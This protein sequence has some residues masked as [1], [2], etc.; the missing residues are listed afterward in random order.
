MFI[1][2]MLIMMVFV[3]YVKIKYLF[4]KNWKVGLKCFIESYEI[5]YN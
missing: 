3:V 4:Y 5:I 2:F 1:D